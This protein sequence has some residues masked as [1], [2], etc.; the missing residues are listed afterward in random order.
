VMHAL[1]GLGQMAFTKIIIVVDEEVDVQNLSEVI[2]RVGNNIEPERDVCFVRGPVD[3]LDHASQLPGFGSK[4]GIDAT[5]KLPGEGFARPWPD[6]IEMSPDV[7]ARV[8]ALL[9]SLRLEGMR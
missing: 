6:V 2:W 5:R 7:K 3:I 1:W 4:M 8:D 9:A